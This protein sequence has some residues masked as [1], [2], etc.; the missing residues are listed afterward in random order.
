MFWI[1]MYKMDLELDNLKWLIC[2]KTKPNKIMYMIYMYK[3]DLAFNNL[4]CLTCHKI[5]SGLQSILRDLNNAKICLI[6]I[7]LSIS[8]F[9]CHYFKPFRNVSSA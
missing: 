7:F 2:R 8:N 6:F 1:H 5:K 9:F 4:Q 3:E